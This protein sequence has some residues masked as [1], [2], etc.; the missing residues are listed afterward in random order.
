VRDDVCSLKL[1]IL[2]SEDSAQNDTPFYWTTPPAAVPHTQTHLCQPSFRFIIHNFPV[3]KNS[4]LTGTATRWPPGDTK[5]TSP[6]LNSTLFTTSKPA[7][8]LATPWM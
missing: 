1:E 7:G 3:F 2:R 8:T 6:G 4:C 5:T